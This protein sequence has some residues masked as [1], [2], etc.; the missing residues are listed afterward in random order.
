MSFF[1][2][3]PHPPQVIPSTSIF[4]LYIIANP[5][6][7]IQYTNGLLCPMTEMLFKYSNEAAED[8]ITVPVTMI[9]ELFLKSLLNSLQ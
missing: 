9:T 6:P 1:T 4:P 2:L 3:F 7:L 5:L 8:N